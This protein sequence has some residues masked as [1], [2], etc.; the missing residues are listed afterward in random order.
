MN[1]VTGPLF[2]LIGIA[3]YFLPTLNGYGRGH[4]NAGPIMIVNLFLGWTLLGWVVALAWS[5]SAV[6]DLR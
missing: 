5:A 3:V 1:D 2:L 4:H 6:H